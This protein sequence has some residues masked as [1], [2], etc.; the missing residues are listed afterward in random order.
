MKNIN[1]ILIGL[2]LFAS[3]GGVQ[4]KEY[5]QDL[6][7]SFYSSMSEEDLARVE[8][9]CGDNLACYF[10]KEEVA[11]A[12]GGG[13]M[14]IEAGLFD[15]MKMENSEKYA[16]EDEN[17]FKEVQKAEVRSEMR[18]E[19]SEKQ[20]DKKKEKKVKKESSVLKMTGIRASGYPI[21]ASFVAKFRQ[22][23][24]GCFPHVVSVNRPGAH[25]CHN[26]GKAIDVG[27]I[28]CGGVKHDA[29]AEAWKPGRFTQ[30][31]GCMKRKMKTLFHNDDYSPAT[32]T[33]GHWD[34]AHFSNGCVLAGG[35]R[36]Y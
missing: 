5:K 27:A 17:V 7:A 29:F 4:A 33:S 20:Q 16:E 36:Y 30:F 3:A 8:A 14:S 22:C 32:K 21:Y 2:T 13:K 25:S 11:Q 1:S 12:F 15:L 31:V 35:H 10:T 34:H 26:G 9:Y 18:K 28:V 19:Y 24:S 6:P 23:A